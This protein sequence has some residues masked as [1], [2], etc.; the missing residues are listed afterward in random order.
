MEIITRRFPHQYRVRN[1][2]I[3][4]YLVQTKY[5]KSTQNLNSYFLSIKVQFVSLTILNKRD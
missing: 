5:A 1:L 3:V 2:Y 4:W